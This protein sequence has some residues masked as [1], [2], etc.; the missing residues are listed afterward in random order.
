MATCCQFQENAMPHTKADRL[1]DLVLTVFRLS[2]VMTDWGDGFASADGL[3]SARWQMLGAIALGDRAMTAPQLA[4]RMGVTRQG[5]QKQLNLL[6]DAG[7]AEVLPNP[8]HKRSPLYGLTERGRATFQAIDTRWRA[9]AAQA[10][11]AFSVPELLA[12][13]AVLTA[14]IDAHALARHDSPA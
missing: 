3:S 14:L 5:A 9:H 2:G 12:A 4:A 13:E 1:T 11:S 8:M 10:A 6:V 7:L